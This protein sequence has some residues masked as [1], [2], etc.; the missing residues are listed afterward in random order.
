MPWGMLLVGVAIIIASPLPW[1]ASKKQGPGVRK[2]MYGD[3]KVSKFNDPVFGM[4]AVSIGF[5][6]IGLA[7]VATALNS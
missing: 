2:M 3:K 1:I 5:I 4:K 6:V 7:V